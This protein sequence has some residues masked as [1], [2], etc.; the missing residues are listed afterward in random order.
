MLRGHAEEK[1]GEVKLMEKIISSME[2]M[3]LIFYVF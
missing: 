2:G 3:L 1:V